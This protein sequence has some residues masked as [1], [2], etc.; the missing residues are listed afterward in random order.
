M[1]KIL[2]SSL[3][4]GA[5]IAPTL[6]LAQITTVQTATP[7]VRSFE[8]FLAIFNQ[9]INWLFTILLVLAVI[10]IIIAAFK[11]L[12]AGGEEEN[13]K[14][15]HKMI[16]MAVVAIAVAFLAQGVSFIVGQLLRSGGAGT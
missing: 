3:F 15:A 8:G 5:L 7:G 11:Y 12:T 14:K 10:F 13:I 2:L 1:K 6:A 4:A 16:I 9:L